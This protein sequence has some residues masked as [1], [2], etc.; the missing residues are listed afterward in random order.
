MPDAAAD[1]GAVDITL[2]L[3]SNEAVAT[4]VGSGAAASVLSTSVVLA[5]LEAGLLFAVS[6]D[7]PERCFY[8]LTHNNRHLSRS[9]EA[10]LD[11]AK[12]VPTRG[13]ISA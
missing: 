7:L 6:F 9:T 4:A 10:F 11:C 1:A 5:G 8:L 3:P 13:T 12:L 2:E